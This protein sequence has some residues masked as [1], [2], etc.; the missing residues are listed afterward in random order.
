MPFGFPSI[1]G[2]SNSDKHDASL[3]DVL[4]H[5]EQRVDLILLLIAC[6]DRMRNGL[7]ASLREVATTGTKPEPSEELEKESNAEEDRGFLSSIGWTDHKMDELR[8]AS[9]GSLNKWRTSVLHRLGEALSVK[10]DEVKHAKHTYTSAN[11][12][13]N[14]TGAN[15]A[16]LPPALESMD[17]KQRALVLG[18]V[19]FILLSLETYSAYS[20]VLMSHLCTVLSLPA[21]V[22]KSHEASTASTLLATAH[23]AGIDAEDARKKQEESSLFSRKWKVGLATVA[24]AAVIGISGGLAA[25]LLL[26]AAGAI[27][28]GIGLGGLATLLGAT[29]ANPI[30]IAALFGALGGRMTGR[31]MD[32]YSKEVEDFMFLPAEDTKVSSAGPTQSETEAKTP[33]HKLRVAIGISGWVTKASDISLPWR[34]LST[35]SL[36]P[37]SLQ[38]ERKAMT[39]LGSALS[40][41]FKDYAFAYGR[42]YAINLLLPALSAGLAPLGLMKWGKLIDNPFTIAMQ[43]SDKAGKVLARALMDKA[44]GE[45]PVTL[46]GFSLGARVIAACLEELAANHAF[47]LIEDVIMMG[48]P[49]PSSPGTWRRMRAVVTGRLVNTYS[50]H[51]YILGILYRTRNLALN[52]AG[53]EAVYGVPGVENKDVSSIVNGHNQYRLAVGRILKE[54]GYQDLDA[55]RVEQETAELE[56]EQRHEEQVREEAEKQGKLDGLTDEKNMVKVERHEQQQQQQ[57]DN[58]QTPKETEKGVASKESIETRLAKVDIKQD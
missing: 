4:P 10:P 16:D 12:E 56:V 9:M 35:T 26:G 1:T 17:D 2:K 38:Y 37:F 48:T 33:D 14:G 24:G 40:S 3:D 42:G 47:G 11:L 6:I 44:Q 57:Q 58:K 51:D 27:M 46:I 55:E 39:A 21:D 41:F 19:L 50:T 23:K 53:L 45:R 25:P 49:I 20:R 31:A 5:H 13:K 15:S 28:G 22:L 52:I 18:A 30:T 29:I 34:V 32:A 8:T 7:D 54:V 43:R 36:E